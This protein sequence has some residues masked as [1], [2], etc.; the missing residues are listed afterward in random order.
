MLFRKQASLI[1][2]IVTLLFIYSS[3]NKP[4]TGD[5]GGDNAIETIP[6]VA[7]LNPASITSTSAELGGNVSADGGSPVTERGICY[8]TAPQPTITSTKVTVGTGTGNFTTTVN[9]LLPGTVYYVKAYAVNTIGL[10]YGNQ[11]TFTTSAATIEDSAVA[12]YI[13]GGTSLHAI[14]AQTG[15]HKWQK[16]LGDYVTSSP[17][18]AN[19]KVYIGCKNK[20]YAFDTSGNQL[21]TFTTNGDIET[22]APVVENNIVY[23]N[24]GQTRYVYALNATTGTPIWTFDATEPGSGSFGYS[25]VVLYNNTLFINGYWLYAINAATGTLKWKV[26]RTNSAPP[27]IINN[28]VYATQ[29]STN[30][31]NYTLLAL[32]I[33][34]GNILWQRTDN[35]VF[36]DVLS[37]NNDKEKLLIS[38]GS[39]IYAVDTINGN[40]IWHA[41]TGIEGSIQAGCGKYPLVWQN[42]F[43]SRNSFRINAHHLAN[44]VFS[45]ESL[46]KQVYTNMT[47]VNNVMY[48]AS[49]VEI[50]PTVR[51][52]IFAVDLSNRSSFNYK[53]VSAQPQTL[54][55]LVSSP[56]VVTKSGKAHRFGRVFN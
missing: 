13:G 3:C 49:E 16:N 23:F 24:T 42:E 37:F 43:Y 34:T 29:L 53:W 47:I 15:V 28:K 40:L 11:Q 2:V 50:I 12:L 52:H 7:T 41:N 35:V 6:T 8:S 55:Y 51:F 5:D 46:G 26:A 45:W 36:K 32:D 22:T 10:S 27:G 33:N 54:P 48:Y 17:A 44:G 19:G 38:S 30:N 18:Y 56:C 21:W 4:G 39:G 9:N 25:S 20:F 1:F 14:N 31:V